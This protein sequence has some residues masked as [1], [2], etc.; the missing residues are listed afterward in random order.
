ME[1]G[2]VGFGRRD[3]VFI[4][5]S[6]EGTDKGIMLN[7]VKIGDVIIILLEVGEKGIVLFCISIEADEGFM[8]GVCFKKYF[9]QVGVEV[10]ECIVFVVVEEGKGVVIEGFVESEILFISFKEGE[11]GE[12]VVVELEDRVVGFLVVYIV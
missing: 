1:R 2:V 4:V 9:F 10:S 11:S 3:K 12:C 6:I 5:I 7:I 8:M